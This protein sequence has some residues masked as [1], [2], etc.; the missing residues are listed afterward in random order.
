MIRLVAALLP[1][2]AGP[3]AAGD[4]VVS[5][6]LRARLELIGGQVRPGFA[7]DDAIVALRTVVRAEYATGPVAVTVELRDA[8]V[9]G[10]GPTSAVSAND[11]NVIDLSV[12]ELRADLGEALGPGTQTTLS[13][14]R[15]M[16]GLGSNRLVDSPD[17][18][19]AT[20]SFTGL[21]LNVESRGWNIDA[22]WAMPVQ[23][24]PDAREDVLANRWAFDREG[25]D[26][27]LW[28]IHAMRRDALGPVG[29]GLTYVGFAERDRPGR[30]TRDR[31]LHSAGPWLLARP[32]QGRFDLDAE[33]YVQ[34]GSL[35]AS[36][37]PDALRQEVLAGFARAEIGYT[38]SGPWAPRV[39]VRYDWASG[40][41]SGA[42]VTRFDRLFGN[43]VADFAVSGQYAA[44]GRANISSPGVRLGV[45]RGPTD[46]YVTARLLWA[47]S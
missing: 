30:P 11:V 9:H 44:V 8:R 27:Q 25:L 16:T 18:R 10:A 42:R 45:Q 24:L 12:L 20:T 17:F 47:D 7:T 13:A 23:R 1:A 14:G 6:Q 38:L 35:S 2:L 46:A 4:L 3:A 21:K 33:A 41:G 40:D 22:L 32:R 37:A 5:A 39:S 19:N 36:L 31:N 26:R 34:W 29:L 43:R 15:M 28:G